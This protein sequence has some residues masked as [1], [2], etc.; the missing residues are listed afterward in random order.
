[1]QTKYL[2]VEK[3]NKKVKSNPKEFVESCEKSFKNQLEKIAE[4]ILTKK[5]PVKVILIGGPSC[6]G[7][8]TSARMLGEILKKNGKKVLSLEMDNFFISR[9]E[10]PRLP[11][12]SVD[13]DSI[14]IVN[15]DLIEKCFTDLFENG[16]SKLPIYDFIDGIS[17]PDQKLV[18]ADKDT[19]LIFEGIH[20]LNPKLIKKLGTKDIYKIFICNADGYTFNGKTIEPREFRMVR[21]MVRDVQ[22]R[23]VKISN[24]LKHW[25]DVTDAEDIYIMPHSTG[26]NSKIN[27]S[28]AYEINLYKQEIVDALKSGEITTEQVP[29][30]EVFCNIDDLD[31]NLLPKSTLMKEFINFD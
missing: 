3:V 28:H 8:T 19:I 13:Y 31:R 17:K 21:R 30:F 5:T 2:D 12:G 29:W 20:T 1:M 22:F 11:N 27:T 7:K 14:N 16:N 9:D 15:L 6:S 18:K 10:R 23:A 24:T 4:K 26:V 25:H